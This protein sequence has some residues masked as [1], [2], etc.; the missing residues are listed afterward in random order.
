MPDDFLSRERFNSAVAGLDMQSTPG[1]PYMKEAPTVGE[2][3]KCDFIGDFD[4]LRM[5]R[6]WYDTCKVMRD[7]E[8]VIL[9][10]FIKQEPHSYAKLDAGRFRLI[11]CSPLSVQVA[12]QMLFAYHNDV[13]IAKARVLPSQQ[14]FGLVGGDWKYYYQSWVDRGMTYAMDKSAWDWTAPYWALRLDLE[15]R[16]RMG[17]GA[18]MDRWREIAEIL[19]RQMFERPEII[20]SDGSVYRQIVPGIMKS[21]CVNTI[22]TNGHCQGF[23]HC[24][25]CYRAGVNPHPLPRVVGDDTLSRREH[26]VLSGGYAEF[27]VIVKEVVPR[28]Q[29]VGYEW[30]RKGLEPLYFS[31][32]VSRFR[33][34]EQ[35]ILREYLDSIMRMYV[36]SRHYEFWERAVDKI[37]GGSAYSRACLR[38]WMDIGVS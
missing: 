10:V 27:G 38:Y 14:G 30:S 6:L 16:Y 5:E 25:V 32:H 31:K 12:W 36:H 24:V 1:Y 11:L 4:P 29:F 23:V 19:Y 20:L 8:R 7:E 9:R 35:Q 18:M 22:S 28:I 15:F 13:E 3:L 26:A 17:R 37:A 21:G 2:W 33:H 34:I